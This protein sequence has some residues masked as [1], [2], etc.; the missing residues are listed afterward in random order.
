MDTFWAKKKKTKKKKFLIV[1]SA[2]R[3]GSLLLTRQFFLFTSK[4]ERIRL[5]YCGGWLVTYTRFLGGI[6]RKKDSMREV[7]QQS[8]PH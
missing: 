1:V 8:S 5:L 6:A 2:L 3:E 7:D 4:E